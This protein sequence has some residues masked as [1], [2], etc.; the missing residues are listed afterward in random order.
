MR[1]RSLVDF[2]YRDDEPQVY[3]HGLV[4][5]EDFKAFF[6][7]FDFNL[8]QQ[9]RPARKPAAPCLRLFFDGPTARRTCSST[10]VES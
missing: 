9:L 10:I 2:K 3:G 4:K 7:D 1:S 6:L 5:R 8:Y